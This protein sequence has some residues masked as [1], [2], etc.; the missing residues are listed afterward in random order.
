[1]IAFFFI[2]SSPFQFFALHSC[3][4]TIIILGYHE[5]FGSFFTNYP[6][7]AALINFLPYRLLP[8]T[9]ILVVIN[10]LP[11]KIS[12]PNWLKWVLYVNLITTVG[13][14]IALTINYHWLILKIIVWHSLLT[15][16][17]IIILL[18]DAYFKRIQFNYLIAF[19]FFLSFIGFFFL[20]LRL[21]Q[22]IDY[23]WINTFLYGCE[24]FKII[25]FVL[26]ICR[27][28]INYERERIL[29]M[30]LLLINNEPEESIKFASF[31]KNSSITFN[32]T[33]LTSINSRKVINDD[34]QKLQIQALDL[35]YYIQ[36]KVQN[37]KIQNPKVK[38]SLSQDFE[39]YTSYFDEEKLRKILVTIL[40]ECAKNI[41]NEGEITCNVKYNVDLEMVVIEVANINIVKKKRF[42][43]DTIKLIFSNKNDRWLNYEENKSGYFFLKELVLAHQAKL[44]FSET[45]LLLKRFKLTVPIGL[46]FWENM[47]SINKKENSILIQLYQADE[48]ESNN[49][50]PILPK[51]FINEADKAFIQRVEQIIEDNLLNR[52]FAI[53]NLAD[54]LNISSVQL[55]RKLKI[56][57]NITT[58]EFIRNYRLKR[59]ADL[60][61]NRSGNISDVAFQVGFE[62]LSYFT[63]V[64]QEFFGKSPSEWMKDTK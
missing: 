21:L 22:F 59:A 42:G 32:D 13:L 33:Q 36:K 63:K 38:L 28:I 49:L 12:Y 54:E 31:L 9:S 5:S 40:N 39:S 52:S 30:K 27:V 8:F 51:S 18:I 6:I 10:I 3:L 62:S 19:S 50:I 35:V 47:Q 41:T 57:A 7:Y 16:L 37:F 55:R 20:Q 46:S 4:T 34:L 43:L 23:D 61:K 29:V 14:T 25:F 26:L 45:Y 60:L 64:F 11:I 53:N 56:I 2:R 48:H 15:E 58:V 44:E 24:I 17:L 1:M